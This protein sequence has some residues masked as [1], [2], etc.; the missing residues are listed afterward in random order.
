MRLRRP[1]RS[2]LALFCGFLAVNASVL[3]AARGVFASPSRVVR[4]F[5]GLVLLVWAI[6]AF[7][8][9]PAWPLLAVLDRST[10]F[11]IAL[12]M[13]E[14]TYAIAEPYSVADLLH[15]PVAMID[16][17]FPVILAAPSGLGSDVDKLLAVIEKR[18]ARLLTISDRAEVLERSHA[19]IALPSGVPEWLSPIV[20]IGPGQVW[21]R[22]LALAKGNDPDV[23]RG[24][25]KVTLTH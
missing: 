23:P 2:W 5:E 21:A 12:K 22:S 6:V 11:E 19:R 15:G 16:E 9:F 17:G 14:T 3:L 18:R 1:G 8:Q 7:I 10:A 20:A 24:L 4:E 25:N 13:K